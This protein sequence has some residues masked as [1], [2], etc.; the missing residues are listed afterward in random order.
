A[1]LMPVL[2]IFWVVMVI[3]AGLKANEGVAYRY[4]FTLRL[5]K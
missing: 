4:P 1:V 5:I 3:I 2:F